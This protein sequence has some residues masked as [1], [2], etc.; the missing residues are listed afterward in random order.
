[1]GWQTLHKIQMFSIL[2]DVNSWL[3]QAIGAGCC[4]TNWV[5]RVTSNN[6]CLLSTYGGPEAVL[7]HLC[8]LNLSLHQS[9]EIATMII[10]PNLQ[11][12]KLKPRKFQQ[13]RVTQLVVE[14][15][16][17]VCVTPESPHLPTG[18]CCFP[19]H[20]SLG[21]DKVNK[22]E[23]WALAL[24]LSPCVTSCVTS[25]GLDLPVCG[26]G[27]WSAISSSLDSREQKALG[28]KNVQNIFISCG[29]R[30]RQCVFFPLIL[31]LKC[32]MPSVF[33][34]AH[35]DRTFLGKN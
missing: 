35:Q 23:H 12:R 30:P 28:K 14:T 5:S 29:A 15:L 27:M 26:M 34:N 13:P 24:A 19:R 6:H 25:P 21:M 8:P 16:T 9:D 3:C 2:Q 10:I 7:F 11:M 1:M 4:A 20:Y 22:Q 18:P 33:M 32:T 17:Q 31:D